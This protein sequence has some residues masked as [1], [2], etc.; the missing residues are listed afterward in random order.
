MQSGHLSLQ[1]TAYIRY[2]RFFERRSADIA[3]GSRQVF[4]LDCAI[5]DDDHIFQIGGGCAQADIQVGF[6]IPDNF[7]VFKSDVG[8]D[9]SA[10]LLYGDAIFASKVGRSTICG[11]FDNDK[12]SDERFSAGI[13]YCSA[14]FVGGGSFNCQQA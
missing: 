4:F 1:G 9:Q 8:K 10:S 12:R 7:L 13:A 11:S 3:D 14:Y 2:D 6:T 5:A